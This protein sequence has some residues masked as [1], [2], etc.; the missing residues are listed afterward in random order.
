MSQR[1]RMRVVVGF[2]LGAWCFRLE[3]RL[4]IMKVRPCFRGCM[5]KRNMTRE[6]DAVCQCCV[7]LI[8]CVHACVRWSLASLWSCVCSMHVRMAGLSSTSLLFHARLR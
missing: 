5:K 8:L 2:G 6:H 4:Y 3:F 1:G 7:L